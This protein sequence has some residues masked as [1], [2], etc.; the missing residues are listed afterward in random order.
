MKDSKEYSPKIKKLYR[1]LKKKHS[2]VELPVYEDPVEALVYGLVCEKM[3]QSVTDSAMKRFEEY[4]IDLNDLRVSRSEE[5]IE[6]LGEKSAAS[7]SI[8]VVL[9]KTLAAVFDKYNCVSLKSLKKIG[10]KPARQILE[11]LEGITPFA[12]NYCVLTALGGQ[13]APVTERMIDYLKAYELV[14]PDADQHQIEGFLARQIPSSNL[15]EFYVLLRAQSESK[16]AKK[17]KKTKKKTKKKT[18]AKSKKKVAAKKTKKATKKT[19]K[20]TQK[21][22]KKKTKKTRKKT[23]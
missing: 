16:K 23:R 1:S 12:V 22:T 3:T 8:A 19:K 13:A 6:L 2:K 18:T 11:K 10:K 17:R 7:K 5:V 15:Y 20:K 9:A 21:K 14:H 4:F